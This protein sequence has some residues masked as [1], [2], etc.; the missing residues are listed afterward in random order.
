MGQVTVNPDDYLDKLFPETKA[1]REQTQ[2]PVK[3]LQSLYPDMDFSEPEP[4]PNTMGSILPIYKKPG[5]KGIDALLSGQFSS[6]AGIVGAAKRTFTLPYEAMTGQVQVMNPQG[7]TSDDM[8]ARGVEFA[9][10][11]APTTPAVRSG[12]GLVPGVAN[13][14]KKNTAVPT[15]DELIQEGRAGFNAMRATGATYPTRSTGRM[16]DITKAEM[17]NAGFDPDLAP[18]TFKVLE[19]L[20]NPNEG[21]QYAGINNLHTVRKRLG[22]ISQEFSNPTEQE[23]ARNVRDA[24]DQFIS[25]QSDIPVPPVSPTAARTGGVGGTIQARREAAEALKEANANYSAGKRGQ[26]LDKAIDEDA[27]MQAEAANSGQNIGNAYRQKV[28]AALRNEKK[29]SGYTQ[30]EKDVLRAVIRGSK[31]ANRTRSVGNVLGGGGGLGMGITAGGGAGLGATIGHSIGGPVGAY[32]GGSLGSM[33]LPGAG[34]VTKNLSNKITKRQ[35]DDA[36]DF[37]LKRS[38]VY[39][40]RHASTPAEMSR[41][42]TTEAI[43]RA[44]IAG[45]SAQQPLEL[46]VTGDMAKGR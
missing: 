30:Q 18:K 29:V 10:T 25:G 43:I 8:I 21:A 46:T 24:L 26:F 15:P 31:A 4:E 20:I 42:A 34:L 38:P 9:G 17:E 45:G 22:K 5:Q 27:A 1:Q 13:R 28:K 44:L 23:A 36:R 35:F 12:S 11:V 32:I 37:I 3:A 19:S 16:A 40:K 14:W 6:D 7:K 41:E 33:A 2:D 39:Q